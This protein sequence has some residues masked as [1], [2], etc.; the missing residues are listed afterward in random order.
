MLRHELFI[1]YNGAVPEPAKVEGLQRAHLLML[2]WQVFEVMEFDAY[3]I[4]TCLNHL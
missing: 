2:L 3:V 1:F 4:G